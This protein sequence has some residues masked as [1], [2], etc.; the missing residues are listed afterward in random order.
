M[1]M[2]SKRS[3]W[4][5]LVVSVAFCLGLSSPAFANTVYSWTTDDG[6][7][8]YTDDIKRIPAKFRTAA[9]ATQVGSLKSYPRYTPIERV[10]YTSYTERMTQRL[11]GL[12]QVQ[13][14]HVREARVANGG[15]DFD[16]RAVSLGGSRYGNGVRY[17]VPMAGEAA[18]DDEPTV[19]ETMRVKPEG[20][21]ATRSVTVVR[22][23]GCV[24]AVT[25]SQLSQRSYAGT[26]ATGQDE[27]E[28]LR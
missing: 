28:A 10:N 4:A 22:Q 26:T 16:G 7:V 23:G 1:L 27:K 12:R 15:S 8:A 13:P 20:S 14:A 18:A 5:V 19:I 11:Q 21:L 25:K 9:K 3:R 17:Q 6:G 24:I 2:L